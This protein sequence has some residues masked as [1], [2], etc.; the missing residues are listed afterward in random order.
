MKEEKWFD[1]GELWFPFCM[2]EQ[3]IKKETSLGS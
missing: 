1:A 3:D 2:C